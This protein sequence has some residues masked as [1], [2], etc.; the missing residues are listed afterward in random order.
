M[1]M[2]AGLILAG[3]QPDIVNVLARANEAGQQ[4]RQFDRQN[5][6][7][8]LYQEQGPQIAAGDQNAL[9]ALARFDPQA[10]LGITDVRLGQDVTRQGMAHAD[11]R[12]GMDQQSHTQGL[13]MNAQSMQH[14]NANQG[15]L[16]RQE[17]R[18]IEQ[19][20]ARL[21]AAERASQRADI[22]SDLAIL[23]TSQTP[24]QWDQN[25]I[26]TGNPDMAGQFANRETV[27][28]PY[29]GLAE[30]LDRMGGGQ[31]AEPAGVQTLRIRAQEAGL[32]QGTPEYQQF[33][34]SGGVPSQS[35]SLSIDPETGQVS[36]SQGT[37]TQ[38]SN[39]GNGKDLTV[40]A[41]KNTGFLLRAQDSAEILNALESEGTDLGAKIANGIPILGN[42]LQTPEYRQYDQARRDFIN[43]VLRRESG[44]VIADSE[45]AN[46]ERQYFPQ[47]GDDPATIAQK[48]LN[49]TNAIA[50]FEIGAGDGA[51]RIDGPRPAP[52]ATQQPIADFSGM[53]VQGVLD[54]DLSNA[55]L[56]EIEAWN[57]RLTEL[58]Q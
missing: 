3:Q 45:F 55:S 23:M 4:A 17:Q 31:S 16:S 11:T 5:A 54:F 20:A 46:A 43:A 14:A 41:A 29:I 32:Q 56:A 49:R 52:Q 50:G 19:H 42:Y 38:Q 1:T 37:G 22:E 9:N 26:A 6:V 39:A 48:R 7:N 30:T 8:A 57:A 34:A 2:N 36:F 33:M 28:A 40:D 47:P 44:A 58:G 13:A 53:D 10:S 35:T 51:N 27:I 25:A 12:L 24:E 15:R 18:Q 21:S